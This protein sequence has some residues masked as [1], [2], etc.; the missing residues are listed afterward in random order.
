MSKVETIIREEFDSRCSMMVMTY[1]LDQVGMSNAA[2]ITDEQIDTLQGN[3]L[4]TEN[5][6][7]SL[8]RCARRIARECSFIEDVVPFIANDRRDIPTTLEEW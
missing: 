1:L 6:V 8:V 5:F 2:K 3:G 7:K 4:M